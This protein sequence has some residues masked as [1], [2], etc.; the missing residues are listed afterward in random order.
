[1]TRFTQAVSA[2]GTVNRELGLIPEPRVIKSKGATID[3]ASPG[4]VNTDSLID[5]TE[6]T[7]YAARDQAAGVNK[8]TKPFVE[9][10]PRGNRGHDGPLGA[11]QR[12]AAAGGRVR[13]RGGQSL[14][15][16]APVRRGDVHRERDERL[17][18]GASQ[19]DAGFAVHPHLH[20]CG[21][22][23]PEHVCRARWL[24]T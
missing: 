10:G 14:H 5:D 12:D 11:G 15:R 1:M 3:G 22:R 8:V 17:L 19:W 9:R 24:R 4:S 2:G 13:R 20:Q 16:P 18:V 23:L 21:E 6:N 7:N